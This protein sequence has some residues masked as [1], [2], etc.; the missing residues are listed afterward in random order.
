MAKLECHFFPETPAVWACQN[1]STHYGEKAIPQGRSRHWGRQGPRCIRCNSGLDHLGNA[2]DAK[3]FWQML[4]HFFRYPLHLNSMLVV[5][6]VVGLSLLFGQNLFTVFLLLLAAAIVVKYSFAIIEQR[7]SGDTVPPRLSAVISGDEH[8][9]FLRQIAVLFLMGV[10]VGVAGHVSQLLGVVVAAFLTLATPAS[11][12]LL[13]IEKSV[14]RALDPFALVAL[15]FAVGWP[16]LLLWFCVQVISAGPVYVLGWFAAALPAPAVL[17]VLAFVMVYF[18]FSLYAMLGY[19]LFEYQRELGFD[20]AVDDDDEAAD[21]REFEKLRALGES[22]VLTIDGEY[23]RARACLRR[24]LDVARDDID[25]H[26]HYHKL[27]MLL[28]DD[29]ALANHCDYLVGILARGNMLSRAVPVLLDVQKRIPGFRL[30]NTSQAIEVAKL[31]QMQGQHKSV[32]RLFQNFHKTH[33]KDPLLPDAYLL[34]ATILFEYLGEDAKAEAIIKFVLNHY[35]N[36]P[37]R[38]QY[39]RL[40]SVIRQPSVKPLSR[41]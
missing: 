17:P 2:T 27:L 29:E 3:P 9:L 25:L 28:N 11:I 34:V 26:L 15:M 18:T 16:Y 13:A 5:A 36:H 30:A 19:V 21:F 31:L 41:S 4:P 22:T 14:R 35:P 40:Q 7:G 37:S 10:A 24:A 8:H 38:S 33:G 12:M 32:I 1:C 20:A 23:E 39:E 6:L